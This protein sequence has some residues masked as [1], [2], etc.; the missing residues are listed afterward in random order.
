MER[1][2]ALVAIGDIHGCAQTL[3]ALLTQLSNQC[4][5]GTRYVFL[6]DYVDRGPDSK[7]VIDLLLEFSESYSC[8]FLEGNHEW[9]MTRALKEGNWDRWLTYGGKQT[10]ESYGA[11]PQNAIAR[12]PDTHMEFLMSLERVSATP[13]FVF[14]HGG[15]NPSLSIEENLGSETELNRA[16][17]Q[18]EHIEADVSHWE[19][20]VVFGHTPVIDPILEPNKI[21]ID[22]GCVY[23]ERGMGTLT[24]I[25]LPDNQIIQQEQIENV[26]V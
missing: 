5:A 8:T 3:S 11:H 26:T 4:A 1:E 6:G 15:L 7:S 2:P 17:W 19:R 18:R 12:I 21:G 20:A 9:M 14:V 24:A 23:P 22:T 10:L 25:V 16:L 13:D